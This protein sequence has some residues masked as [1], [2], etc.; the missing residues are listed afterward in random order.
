MNNLNDKIL[1]GK[2][3]NFIYILK[4]LIVS[5]W[6]Y[7]KLHCYYRPKWRNRNKHN[8]TEIKNNMSWSCMDKIIVWN[9]TFWV[10]DVRLTKEIE[11]S[12]LRI[13]NYCCIAQEVEFIWLANHPIDWLTNEWIWMY[14]YHHENHNSKYKWYLKQNDKMVV[15]N[16]IKNKMI[17]CCKGPIIIDDDVWIWTWAKI[18]SWVH[19]WQWTIVGA[20]AVVTKST[21]P[22]GIVAWVPAKLIRY[23]FPEEKIKQLLKIDFSRISME[24][25]SKM[26][27]ETISENFNIWNIKTLMK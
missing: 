13:W 27:E 11:N 15:D 8:L 7:F 26:Y 10:L 1:Y 3:G 25:L 9:Y 18:M 12:F 4:N 6:W 23:R 19:L 20:W 17:K 14:M 24:D 22:Y 5:I 21:P 16:A 2:S